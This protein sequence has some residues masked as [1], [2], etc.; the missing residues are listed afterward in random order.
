MCARE[1]R[2]ACTETGW[3]WATSHFH[4]RPVGTWFSG[5]PRTSVKTGSLRSPPARPVGGPVVPEDGISTVGLRIPLR[6]RGP[7]SCP[8]PRQT[9]RAAGSGGTSDGTGRSPRGPGSGAESAVSPHETSTLVP[10]PPSSVLRHKPTARRGVPTLLRGLDLLV[11]TGTHLSLRRHLSPSSVSRT[12]P[13]RPESER[14][15]T[16]CSTELQTQSFVRRL[17]EDGRK[18]GPSVA[19]SGCEA[20]RHPG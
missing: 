14:G 10:S 7:E 17:C 3:T 1:G 5:I 20:G 9:G 4:T 2:C 19:V 6:A 8:L 13:R 15:E 18:G 16:G 12:A 11:Q